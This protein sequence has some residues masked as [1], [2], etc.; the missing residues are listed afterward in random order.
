MGVIFMKVFCID[1]SYI[2]IC[3][4]GY[5]GNFRVYF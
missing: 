3:F 4:Y 5:I 2:C 1:I